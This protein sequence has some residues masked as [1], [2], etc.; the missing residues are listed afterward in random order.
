MAPTLTGS[1]KRAGDPC[2]VIGKQW[3]AY[4]PK[5]ETNQSTPPIA[6]SASGIPRGH[7]CTPAS[8]RVCASAGTTTQL[9]R[10]NSQVRERLCKQHPF[11]KLSPSACAW[12][13]RRRRGRHTRDRVP[14]GHEFPRHRAAAAPGDVADAGHRHRVRLFGR[15]V[16]ADAFG[17]TDRARAGQRRASLRQRKGSKNCEPMPT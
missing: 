1:L 11:M 17:A 5:T 15:H 14:D 9:A 3:F 6:G 12:H 10:K 4:P 2:E 16:H 13:K 7:P 8:R